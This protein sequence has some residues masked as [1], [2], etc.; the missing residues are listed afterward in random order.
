MEKSV[1]HFRSTLKDFG[2]DLS[3]QVLFIMIINYCRC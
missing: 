1:E 2:L 3:D